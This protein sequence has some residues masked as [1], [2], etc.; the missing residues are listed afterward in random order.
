MKVLLKLM[1]ITNDED[2]ARIA[3][4]YGVDRIFVDLEQ[5]GKQERQGGMDTVQSKH[6]LDDVKKIKKCL[7]NSELLVRSNPIYENSKEEIDT[8]VKNGADVVML[9]Y[10]KTCEEVQQFIDYVGGRCRT[11][12]LLETPE[13]AEMI[14]D[15]LDIEGIDE[16]H[17]GLNDLHLGYKKKFMFELLVDG[18]V[19][20]LCDKF[21][22]KGMPYGFG[23][24]AGLGQGML[25]AESIIKEHYRL[26]SKMVILSRSFC[27]TSKLTDLEE[28]EA[29][30]KKGTQDIRE[31]EKQV[32]REVV[33]KNVAYFEENK[34]FV[35]KVVDQIV[36]N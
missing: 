4:K 5:I 27:N 11:C 29:V 26:G 2:V 35:E 30:F 7:N 36:N 32:D 20:R 25:P 13:A 33:N 3:D 19:E 9:P 21:K 1:Y 17:I 23:G 34:I 24:I 18:T 8:I 6:T 14:D 16:I 22:Q 31:F 15:I 10:F 28:I 12:L